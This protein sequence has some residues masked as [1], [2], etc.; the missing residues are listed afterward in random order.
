MRVFILVLMVIGPYSASAALC[1]IIDKQFPLSVVF[2]YEGPCNQSKF[3]GK[4]GDANKT[5]HLSDAEL[6]ALMQSRL[7]EAK[8][9]S[10]KQAARRAALKTCALAGD[11]PAA[12][13]KTCLQ[14]LVKEVMEPDFSQSEL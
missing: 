13:M 8:Q 6:Q 12:Q 1:H 3:T 9:R 10:T 14:S 7:D 11:L 5:Q 4:F 2:Q